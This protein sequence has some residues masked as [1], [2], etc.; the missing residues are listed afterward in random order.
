MEKRKRINIERRDLF[1]AATASLASMILLESAPQVAHSA[2]AIKAIYNLPESAFPRMA[3]TVDDGCS[4]ESLRSYIELAIENDLRFTFFVYSA[5]SPWKSQSKLLKPLVESGQ[6]QLANHSH[7]HRDLTTLS[8][9]EIKKDLT[10]CHN[11]IEKTYGVDARPYFRA[12]FGTLNSGVINAAAE[13]GYTKPVAWSGSLVDTQ[14]QS[15]RRLLYH[16][17]NSFQDR[18]I[19]LSHANNLVV[20]KNF[21]ALMEVINARNLSLVTLNDVF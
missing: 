21:D 12:P 8:F 7:T 15:T 18:G 19:V 14:N 16:A 2:G 11:F 6:I 1:K 3:W 5:M 17:E 4:S 13:I 9:T 10:K 20:S